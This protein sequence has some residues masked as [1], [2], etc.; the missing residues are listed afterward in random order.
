[1]EQECSDHTNELSLSDTKVLSSLRHL[2]HQS[3]VDLFDD[4][5][6]VCK[7]ESVP[8]LFVVVL[9]AWVDVVLDSPCEQC[10]LLWDDGE[11]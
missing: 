11:R 2:S 3:T 6:H 7:T 1:M 8:N 9:V 4:S 5:V 10:G